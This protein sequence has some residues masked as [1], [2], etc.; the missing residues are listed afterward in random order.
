M[1]Y[2]YTAYTLENGLIKG[3]IEA[4]NE[5]EAKGEIFR[6]GYKLLRMSPARSLPGLEELFPS[7]YKV[8]TGDLVRFS[9]QFATMVRGGASLQRGLELLE[10]ETGSRVLKRVLGDVRKKVDRG[11]SLSAAFAE[12]P[13]VFNSRFISVVEVGEHTGNLAD[14]MEQLADA[15][16]REHESMQRFKRTMMMPAFTMGASVAMLVLMM[17]V[18]L[19]PLLA[20]FESRGTDIPLVTR[21]ATTIISGI[22]DYMVH[23][24]GT[25]FVLVLGF[26]ILRHFPKTRYGLHVFMTRLPILGSLIVTKEMAQFSRTN[27]MLLKAGVPLAR[28]LPLAIGGCKNLALLRAFKAGEESLITGHGFSVAVGRYSVIPKL[29]AEL[30]IVGEENNVMG[31]T[32]DDL[33]TAY[34]KEV[35]NRLDSLIAI[36]EPA[37]TFVVGGVVLFI[38]LSMFLPIYSG[39]EDLG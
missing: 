16:A 18:M 15:L 30:V 8:K 25:I 39:M 37:S 5:G 21:I 34:E 6:L 4:D 28:S 29:W 38:A 11:G 23:I 26:A 36:L 13:K 19:P 10:R 27:S 20:A 1:Q 35:E 32:F 24:L 9:R 22:Q 7:L 33:A 17:T 31:T 12:F 2:N 14:S 3:T